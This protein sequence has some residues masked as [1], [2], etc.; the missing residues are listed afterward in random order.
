MFDDLGESVIGCTYTSVYKIRQEKETNG[1]VKFS[2]DKD[3][4]KSW[5][6]ITDQRGF[7]GFRIFLQAGFWHQIKTFKTFN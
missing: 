4:T 2:E 6:I 1:D 5:Q 3:Q 7:K